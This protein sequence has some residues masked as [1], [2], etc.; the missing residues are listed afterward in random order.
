MMMI[1]LRGRKKV[2]ANSNIDFTLKDQGGSV[3]LKEEYHLSQQ[4]QHQQLPIQNEPYLLMDVA[5]M[6][7]EERRRHASHRLIGRKQFCILRKHL[8][9]LDFSSCVIPQK[10]LIFSS[11]RSPQSAWP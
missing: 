5:I 9:S 3:V 6:K 4:Q 8:I 11:L 10:I 7:M 2:S 1:I